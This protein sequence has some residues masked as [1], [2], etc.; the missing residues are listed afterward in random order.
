MNDAF[1]NYSFISRG[2]GVFLNWKF[3][4]TLASLST[5]PWLR[6]LR[7][8]KALILAF[9]YDLRLIHRVGRDLFNWLV[10]FH[11]PIW[12]DFSFLLVSTRW[13]LRLV[14]V[15]LPRFGSL[16][17]LKQY[18]RIYDLIFESLDPIP[19]CEHIDRLSNLRG[20]SLVPYKGG[21]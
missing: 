19:I 15:H 17:H 3:L 20:P 4:N 13:F 21:L 6:V 16:P 11:S 1:V 18:I 5:Y 7:C 8:Y 10:Y 2:A 12:R 14:D 9:D